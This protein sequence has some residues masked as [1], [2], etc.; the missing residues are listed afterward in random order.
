MPTLEVHQTRSLT[1]NYTV[2]VHDPETKST[3]CIDAADA[4]VITS[5]C[6]E[7]GWKLTHVLITHH[8]WD[9]TQGIADL[10]A[11]HGATVIGPAAESH[12]IAGLDRLVRE[13]DTV[14]VGTARFSVIE[15]PGHTLGHVSFIERANGL[16][17]VGDTL[18]AMGCG[19]VI[20]GDY[21][22]MWGSLKKLMALPPDTMIFCGHDYDASNGQ[23]AMTIEP[24]NEALK[25]RARRAM[26][27]EKGVP[28]RLSDELATNPFLR[29]DQPE[30]RAA[31]RMPDGPAWK[32]FGE[33]RERK[34]RS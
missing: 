33:I 8:H 19:R 5:A 31:L 1:D 4:A 28:M 24:G 29:A 25:E 18:F 32:V 15:T 22:M 14:D 9:H 21:P 10:K 20:E 27:G 7:R 11:R 12:K 34:N 30:V 2:L 17:F 23:F 6:A 3:A 26:A 13:G 16:A